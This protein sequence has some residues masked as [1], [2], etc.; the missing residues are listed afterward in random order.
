[1]ANSFSV[2]QSMG[3]WVPPININLVNTALAT[4]QGKYDYHVAKIDS[5]IKEFSSIDLIRPEDKKYLSDRIDGVLGVVNQTQKKNMAS[6]SVSRDIEQ[7]IGTAIDEEVLNQASNSA[8]IRGF[9]QTVAQKREKQPELY[10]DINYSYAL[11][12]AGVED[13]LN[14]KD[15][16][17]KKVDTVGKLNYQDYYDVDKN[18]TG[19]LEKWAK[20]YGFTKY[21]DEDKTNPYY[22]KTTTG[23]RLTP[24]AIENFYSSKLLSDPKLVSQMRMNADYSYSG[25]SDEVFKSNYTTEV[26]NKKTELSSVIAKL[27]EQKKNLSP[28]DE[29]IKQIDDRI[30]GYNEI[31]AT[32]DKDLSNP[33][34]N[35][36]QKQLEI[37]SNGLLSSYQKNFAQD[38][39]TAIDYDDTPMK[40]AEF[41]M[42]VD[43]Y[44]KKKLAQTT[45]VGVGNEYNAGIP[46]PPDELPDVFTQQEQEFTKSFKDIDSYLKENNEAYAKGT[47]D[48]KKAIRNE[49]TKN[50]L[51]ENVGAQG[52]SSE[53]STLADNYWQQSQ[54][55]TKALST[56]NNAVSTEIEKDFNGMLSSKQNINLE[57]LSDTLPVTAKLLADNHTK[58]FRSLTKE[59]QNRVRLEMASNLKEYVAKD[60]IE[61]KHLQN[62][63]TTIDKDYKAPQAPSISGSLWT[64]LK[65]QGQNVLNTTRNI[66]EAFFVDPFRNAEDYKLSNENAANRREAQMNQFN[67]GA[68]EFTKAIN[69]YFTNDQNLSNIQSDEISLSQGKTLTDS[70]S[71]RYE[72]AKKLVTESLQDNQTDLVPN[73]GIAFSPDVDLDKPITKAL[74]ALVTARGGRPEKGTTFKVEPS[75][76]PG[77]VNIIYTNEDLSTPDDK[78]VQHKTLS[79]N[80]TVEVESQFLPSNITNKIGNNSK[81][82]YDYKNP[83]PFKKTQEYTPP[84]TSEDRDNMVQKMRENHPGLITDSDYYTMMS[85]PQGSMF[86]S[87]QDYDGIL[88]TYKGAY[89]LSNED[90]ATIKGNI[91]DAKYSVEYEK[92]P[93]QGYIAKV[94]KTTKNGSEQITNLNMGRINYDPSYFSAKTIELVN[95]VIENQIQK[96]V[97]E[98]P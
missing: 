56:M 62:Y 4:Q 43:E 37:Y 87:S 55:Y 31:V 93:N 58:D 18:L 53:L 22:I 73:T 52:Y 15:K 5:L 72:V 95:S 14:G 71:R 41:Q 88:N 40:V 49:I 63:I 42:K 27:Q 26:N 9:E 48:E 98:R 6:G 80:T 67:N 92:V 68:K 91:V 94:K 28:G 97:I 36:E 33:N 89:G 51:K 54:T 77:K 19:E 85:N 59:Q 39:V 23:E 12:Q 96:Y 38:K 76:T 78:G 57:N 24:D 70:W 32:Y 1:M 10:S 11:K 75:K 86:R 7:Y 64:G 65:S 21:F 13:Y 66:G 25:M 35:R 29:S 81:W 50:V 3:T 20:D 45:G 74:Q 44:N 34:F 69:S 79:A 82:V 2:P 61:K 46:T 84:K 16:S 60:D 47:D 17:G 83:A 90:V 8:R 30:A